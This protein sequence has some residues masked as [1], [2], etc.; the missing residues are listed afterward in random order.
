MTNMMRMK[1]AL[2][3]ILAGLMLAPVAARAHGGEHEKSEAEEAEAK[4]HTGAPSSF[5]KQPAIGTWATCAVSG[6]VFQVDDETDFHVHEGRTYAFCCG[7]CRKKF[8]KN[9]AKYAPATPAK[10]TATP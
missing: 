9:P 4:K 10:S 6:E 3:A 7:G 1:S 5:D 8:K 2:I